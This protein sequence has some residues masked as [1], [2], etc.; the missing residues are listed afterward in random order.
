MFRVHCTGHTTV[1][2][3]HILTSPKQQSSLLSESASGRSSPDIRRF[4]PARLWLHPSNEGR[5]SPVNLVA[6]VAL[7][8]SQ[9]SLS[10]PLL[11]GATL[12][13]HQRSRTRLCRISYLTEPRQAGRNDCLLDDLRDAT[14]LRNEARVCPELPLRLSFA[15]PT[16]LYRGSKTL[17]QVDDMYV[18]HLFYYYL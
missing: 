9:V 8:A 2:R 13:N 17:G 10:S 6:F 3:S 12:N 14:L 1:S 5:T 15:V 4:P 11:R 7:S 16:S 18:H